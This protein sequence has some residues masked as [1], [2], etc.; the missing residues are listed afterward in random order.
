MPEVIRLML[1]EGRMAL[2]LGG[3]VMLLVTIGLMAVEMA[4]RQEPSPLIR[5]AFGDLAKRAH[6]NMNGLC[7]HCGHTRQEHLGGW[8]IGTGTVCHCGH[9]SSAFV[10]GKVES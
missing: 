1:T 6:Q 4:R 2:I 3:V 8:T 10:A 7:A 5:A 9:P